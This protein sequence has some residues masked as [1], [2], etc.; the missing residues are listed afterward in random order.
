MWAKRGNMVEGNWNWQCW[1][2]RNSVEQAREGLRASGAEVSP[3]LQDYPHGYLALVR[4]ELEHERVTLEQFIE[5]LDAG[6]PQPDIPFENR[7]ITSLR[8]AFSKA[9]MDMMDPDFV[10]MDEFQRFRS[11]VSSDD[12]EM[13]MLA[14]RFFNSHTRVLL[15]S[16]TPFRMYMTRDEASDGSFG[17]SSREFHEVMAFLA[18]GH[19]RVMARFREIWHDYARSLMG[20]AQGDAALLLACRRDKATAE[21]AMLTHIARTERTSTHEMSDLVLDDPGQGSLAVR[22]EDIQAYFTMQAIADA[23][24]VRRGLLATDYAKSC[25]YPLSFMRYYKFNAALDA[26]AKKNWAA[27]ERELGSRRWNRLWINRGAINGYKPLDVRHARYQKLKADVLDD[28]EAG[29]LLWVPPSIPYYRPS[30]SSPYA[31][32]EGFSKTLVFS[33][34][35]MVPPALACMLS[36]E[37]EQRNVAAVARREGRNYLYFRG[38]DDED[39]DERATPRSRLSFNERRQDAFLL[40]YPSAYLASVYEPY[41][42]EGALLGI[43]EV[44]TRVKRRIAVDLAEAIGVPELP[45]GIGRRSVE[46]YAFAAMLLDA[47][48]GSDVAARIAGDAAL[49]STYLAPIE[50]MKSMCER[51]AGWDAR[52]ALRSM[53]DDLLDVLADAAIASPAVCALRTYRAKDASAS[54]ALAFEFGLSF[55]TKMR[56]ADA[57]VTVAAVMERRY[58]ADAEQAHWKHVL[59]Y[60]CEGNFQAM[61]DEYFHLMYDGDVET[62]HRLIVGERMGSDRAPSLYK[63]EGQFNVDTY[64]QFKNRAGVTEKRSST[65]NMRMNFAVAFMETRGEK[66]AQRNKRSAIRAAFNSPFRPVVLVTTSVGQEG[67][68][69]HQ[70]CR[71]IAHWNLPT[72]PVDFEQREGRVNRYKGLA[73]RQTLARRYGED[74]VEAWR[75]GAIGDDGDCGR[76]DREHDGESPTLWD[77]LFRIADN[78]E[79]ALANTD[80]IASGLLPY[81]GVTDG[82]DVQHIE[83]LVYNY[84]FSVDEARY[85][86]LLQAVAQYR[87]VLGQPNQEELLELLRGSYGDD[88][89]LGENFEELFLNLSPFCHDTDESE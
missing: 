38:G 16:A 37:V 88:G 54:P 4:Q 21:R 84:P 36:Y 76:D 31:R 8:R 32:S 81:W 59:A 45:R 63:V 33:S 73:V 35:A 11:L 41:A 66:D 39:V 49:N 28:S 85:R 24:G 5:Y 6:E 26:G 25:P 23:A 52:E 55:V 69:F 51:F 17:N 87:A 64:S 72:N 42:D 29:L 19:E 86:Y 65:A 14:K 68:D 58:Y 62:A 48:V 22:K 71:R 79:N 61:L 74:A 83:R 3:A 46:W 1:N 10:I 43:A 80:A 75:G 53:P 40:L 30:A 78:R 27:V 15:L 9:S 57:T 50:V 60:C 2:A 18:D 44:R 34:W 70:Y 82:P 89:D 20:A 12:T 77:E 67:L 47:W 13:G 56:T 7:A